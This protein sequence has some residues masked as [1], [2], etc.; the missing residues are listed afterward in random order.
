MRD[1][2]IFAFDLL[3]MALMIFGILLLAARMDGGS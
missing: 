3:V 1:F 2:K